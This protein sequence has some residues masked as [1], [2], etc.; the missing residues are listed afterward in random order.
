[1]YIF[2]NSKEILTPSFFTMYH[3][4]DGFRYQRIESEIDNAS[5]DK[6]SET[7]RIELYRNCVGD[8]VKPVLVRVMY[9]GEV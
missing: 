8:K 3:H 6:D 7:V 2:I 4:A 1:M 9:R 5:F